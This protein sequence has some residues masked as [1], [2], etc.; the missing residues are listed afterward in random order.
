MPVNALRRMLQSQSSSPLAHLPASVALGLALPSAILGIVLIGM[1]L[2]LVGMLAWAAAIAMIAAALRGLYAAGV[3]AGLALAGALLWRLILGDST[4]LSGAEQMALIVLTLLAGGIGRLVSRD[5]QQRERVAA[6]QLQLDVFAKMI[7]SVLESS[8]DCVKLLA[9]DGSILSINATGLKLIGVESAEQIVGK[10]WFSLWGTEQQKSLA[11]AWHQVLT[12]GH[13]QFDGSCRIFTGERRTWHNTFTLVRTPDQNQPYVVCISCD[14]TD[15]VNMQ[16]TLDTSV[17]QLRGLLNHID[18]GSLAIDNSWTIRFANRCGEQLCANLDRANPVGRSLWEVFPF[19]RDEPASILIRRVMEEQAMQHF[20][21][22][23]APQQLWLSISVFPANSGIYILARDITALK[24]TQQASAEENARLQVAQEIAG[25]G[26]WGFDYDQGSMQFSAR[27]VAMLEMENCAP[28]EYKKH[29][30]DK[31]NARDR[32]ALVQSIINCTEAAPTLDLIVSF[33][34]RDGANKHLHWI[35]RL[36]TDE[37]GNAA[38]MLG[39]IQDISEHLNAQHSLEKARSLVR[40]LVDALPQQIIVLDKDGKLV[41]ANRSWLELRKRYYRNEDAPSNFFE[42]CDEENSKR[43]IVA[44]AQQ[45]AQSI[46]NAE[47]D[48]IEY[49]YTIDHGGKLQHFLLQARALRNNSELLALLVHQETTAL[50]RSLNAASNAERMVYKLAENMP[51]MF[52]IYDAEANCYSYMSPAIERIFGIPPSVVLNKD[53]S[54][55]DYI[56]PDDRDHV[57]QLLAQLLHGEAQLNIDCRIINAQGELRWINNNSISL[58][59]ENGK[60]AQIVGISRDIT[61]TKLYEQQL[62]E[63]AYHDDLTG[64]ANRVALRNHLAQCAQRTESTVLLLLNIDRFKNINDTLGHACGDELLQQVAQRLR[65][66]LTDVFIARTGGDEFAIVCT[67]AQ[68]HTIIDAALLCFTEAFSLAEENAFVT[69]SLGVA[70]YPDDSD[71]IDGLIK[72][73]GAALQRAKAAGRNN[74]QLFKDTMSLPSRE[75]LALENELRSAAQCNEFELFYQGKFDLE[76]GTLVGAEALLRWRSPKRGLISPAE[77]IPLLEETGLIIAVGEWILAEACRQVRHWYEHTGAWLPVAV[78]VSVLQIANRQFGEKAIAILRN[79][80]L[81]AGIIELEITESALMSDIEYGMQL[82]G[83]LKDA[84][85]SIALDDFGTGYSSLGY[86]R[87]F[88]PNTLKIDRSFIADLTI[89]SH[90]REIVAGIIQLA[91][92]LNIHVVAEG[93][94]LVEQRNILGRLGCVCGQGYL[95]GRPLPAEQFESGVL[96]VTRAAVDKVSRA[97][98]AP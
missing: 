15:S 71:S 81:P 83:A 1:N 63:A 3:V 18:E 5:I 61:S 92:A 76:R 30:L 52:W 8:R 34:G 59:D 42:L 20:D 84:G 12:R 60:V 19:K 35:G 4:V 74:Y 37:R 33:P 40:D 95:F 91:K 79:S 57:Q 87:K 56:H 26:D 47:Q 43:T 32:M 6:A 46:L 88:M 14:M 21:Y 78:N 16:Q 72:C 29:L 36:L 86:L 27:A 82:I 97:R 64:F 13:A 54:F 23:F 7:E 69:A 50:K 66:A 70:M 65:T 98:A 85:F 55:V 93:I 80:G 67:T 39:A 53:L 38:R 25:F 28:H 62:L 17:A 68:R 89:E 9:T 96:M 94:E 45:A 2:H 51:E 41:V 90:D 24:Q 22:F 31:L 73:A 77:F 48:R 10:N 11:S 49:E 44:K 58:R 75:R